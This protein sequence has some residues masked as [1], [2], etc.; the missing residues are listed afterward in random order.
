[1]CLQVHFRNHTHNVC[2]LLHPSGKVGPEGSSV[3][4]SI[5]N[6]SLCNKHDK[7]MRCLK[8]CFCSASRERHRYLLVMVVAVLELV[9]VVLKV[10]QR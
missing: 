10:Q 7:H 1:M 4:D 5:G 3:A 9:L 2:W 6:L 8:V